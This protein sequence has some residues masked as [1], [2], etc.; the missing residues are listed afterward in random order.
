VKK[1]SEDK[2]AGTEGTSAPA[3]ED[4]LRRLTEIVEKLETGDLPLEQSLVLFEEGVRLAQSSQ[5]KLDAAEKRVERLLTLDEN[6]NPIV[7]EVE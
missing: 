7:R 4:S 5:Q 1:E 3:F 2:R 6:G